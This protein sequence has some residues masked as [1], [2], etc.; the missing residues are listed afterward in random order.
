MADIQIR[1]GESEDGGK[2]KHSCCEVLCR[3]ILRIIGSIIKL[4][5]KSRL[6]FSIMLWP[7]CGKERPKSNT[8]DAGWMLK[9]IWTWRR[10]EKFLKR[11]VLE[12][13]PCNITNG[14]PLNTLCGVIS[15][16]TITCVLLLG[17]LMTSDLEKPD[18]ARRHIGVYEAA[19]EPA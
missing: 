17:P 2:V 18:S 8:R 1:K 15:R 5:T 11:I 10:R 12:C 16:K 9:L 14:Y 19:K 6:V 13:Q 3:K 7:L 4:L